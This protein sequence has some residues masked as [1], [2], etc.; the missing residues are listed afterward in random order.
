M[1]DTS[2]IHTCGSFH[3]EQNL[4]RADGRG[5]RTR[6][7]EFSDRFAAAYQERFRQVHPG[8]TRDRTLFVRELA[9]HGNGIPDLVVLS[10]RSALGGNRLENIDLSEAD[11]TIRSF[12]VKL[13]DW[14]AGLMQA[15]RYA[16]FSNVAV[17]VV[18]TARLGALAPHDHLFRTL[19]VGIWGFDSEAGTILT[20]Y[21]PRPKKRRIERSGARAF[22]NAMKAASA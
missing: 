20:V 10:W 15:H 6:E 17:L 2:T 12:E 22:A 21:T 14:R 5:R 7:A 1:L 19:R 16:Y 4:T 11:S 9:V 18:P 3:P 8:A 13:A